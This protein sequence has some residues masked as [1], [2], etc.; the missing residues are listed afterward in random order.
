M[1]D[2]KNEK[3]YPNYLVKSIDLAY[4]IIA[5]GHL[6]KLCRVSPNRYDESK[7]VY[8]FEKDEAVKIM[9]DE[10]VAERRAARNKGD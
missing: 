9:I 6:D 3:E 7:K 5:E 4:N 8:Y 10:Y 1:N 2:Y